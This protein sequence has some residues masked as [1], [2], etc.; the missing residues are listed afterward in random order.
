MNWLELLK[1][2]LCREVCRVLGMG[3]LCHFSVKCPWSLAGWHSG[4]SRECTVTAAQLADGHWC[5]ICWC[6]VWLYLHRHTQVSRT[7][8]GL[9][10]LVFLWRLVFWGPV[11]SWSHWY[12]T[13]SKPL[14]TF[15][16]SCLACI[17]K[18]YLTVPRGGLREREND[19]EQTDIVNSLNQ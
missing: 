10:L 14:E 16:L 4:S 1:Q 9:S 15:P 13:D 11:F 17:E 8:L 12:S 5:I 6:E 3:Q 19:D 7:V 18:Q 2:K